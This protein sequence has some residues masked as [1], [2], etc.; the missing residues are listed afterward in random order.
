MAEFSQF[1]VRLFCSTR[2]LHTTYSKS[3][4]SAV[5]TMGSLFLMVGGAQDGVR[6]DNN[7]GIDFQQI[8]RTFLGRFELDIDGPKPSGRPI[9]S[10]YGPSPATGSQVATHIWHIFERDADNLHKL[11][12]LHR[13]T[14]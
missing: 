9:I 7:F 8:F 14:K 11:V 13:L 1:S 3:F 10:G 2:V 5:S 12:K 6:I 4:T